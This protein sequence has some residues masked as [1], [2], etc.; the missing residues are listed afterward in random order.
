MW[1]RGMRTWSDEVGTGAVSDIKD[2]NCMTSIGDRRCA[3]QLLSARLSCEQTAAGSQTESG[4]LFQSFDLYLSTPQ[5]QDKLYFIQHVLS[6]DMNA[7]MPHNT[8]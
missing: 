5:L 7:G 6:N 1:Y 4:W 3:H 8:L 2:F